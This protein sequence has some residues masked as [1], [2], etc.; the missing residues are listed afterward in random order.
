MAH[1]QS[2]DSGPCLRSQGAEPRCERG[3]L[4]VE[5]RQFCAWVVGEPPESLGKQPPGY[6]P[7]GRALLFVSEAEASTVDDSVASCEQIK[8]PEEL[9]AWHGL[10]PGVHGAD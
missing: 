7:G 9:G 3:N 6:E 8:H 1:A 2:A 4:G 5:F 10:L